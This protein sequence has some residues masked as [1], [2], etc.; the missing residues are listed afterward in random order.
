MR[1]IKY[2]M[3]TGVLPVLLLFL[4]GLYIQPVSGDLT[5]LG[6][7][8]ERDFGWNAMQQ[9]LPI[10]KSPQAQQPKVV[11][12]GDSFSIRNIWQSIADDDSRLTFMTFDW[13]IFSNNIDC[14]EEWLL[15]LKDA[16]PSCD[17]VIIETIE[18]DFLGRFHSKNK[19]CTD[20]TKKPIKVKQGYTK[21]VRNSDLR[22]AMPDPVY[23]VKSIV[24]SLHE[25]EK[26]EKK[27][28][29]FVAP[30]TR[31]DLF[32]NKRSNLILYYENETWKENWKKEEVREAVNK[33]GHIQRLAAEKGITLIFAVV[34]DKSTAY[35]SYFK[36]PTFPA[37]PPDI[38]A[39]F[40][41]RGVNQVDLKQI[42]LQ[43]VDSENQDIYLPNDTHL[44]STGYVLMG[45]A[46]SD[47][48]KAFDP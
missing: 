44:G 23:A 24:N 20:N 21:S 4:V 38:W 17:F 35:A 7:L 39:E 34:P 29:V 1:Y 28:D 18:R 36:Q 5:R 8:S 27:K 13:S 41:A 14:L 40:A 31:T 30:L 42:L 15:S 48:L 6:N 46:I 19:T 26:I 12:V 32:S 43:A 3:L 47:R 2:F 9:Q 22:N 16:Y 45:K 37:P 11:V 33:A 25:F 10:K